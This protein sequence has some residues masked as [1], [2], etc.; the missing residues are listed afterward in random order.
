MKKILFCLA[1]LTSLHSFA[2]TDSAS[3]PITVQLPVKGWAL[4]ANYMSESPAWA[5]RKA[6]DV[7]ALLIGSGT[8]LD[9]LSTGTLRA[10][11]IIS[12]VRR[13]KAE[14]NGTIETVARSIFN[15]APSITGY[16][17][18]LTQIQAKANGAGPQ[19]N[20]ATYIVNQYNSYTQTLSDLYT[21]MIKS[22]IDWSNN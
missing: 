4:M 1:L 9:S 6:P 2:Q 8:Q 20:A 10:A 3:L 18:L 22:G 5:D 12:F 16:T 21:Q 11:Q 13:L 19:K 17:A 14:R 15:N 7:L